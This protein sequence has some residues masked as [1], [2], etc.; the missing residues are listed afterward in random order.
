[1]TGITVKDVNAHGTPSFSIIIIIIIVSVSSCKENIKK[2]RHRK[3]ERQEKR[4]YIRSILCQHPSFS[5]SRQ[6]GL[7]KNFFFFNL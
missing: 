3:R 6:S 2:I 1:M 5:S 4:V 7:D